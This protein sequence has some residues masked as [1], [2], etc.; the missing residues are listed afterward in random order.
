MLLLIKREQQLHVH[1]CHRRLVR[2]VTTI[3]GNGRYFLMRI[4]MVAH[5]LP[6]SILVALLVWVIWS[7]SF[8]Y[9]HGC[10]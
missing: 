2:V 6:A 3:I 5:I 9:M 10:A 7:Q 8:W 1:V 4:Y